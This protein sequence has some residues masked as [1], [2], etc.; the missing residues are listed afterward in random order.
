MAVSSDLPELSPDPSRAIV[1]KQ[2]PEQMMTVGEIFSR[3][4]EIYK[5]HP[6]IVVPSLFPILWAIVGMTILLAGFAGWTAFGDVSLLTATSI[7]GGMMLF[8]IVLVV[9]FVVAQGLTIVMIQDAWRGE[10]VTLSSGWQDARDK[11][12]TLVAASILSGILIALGYLLLIIPGLILTVALYF[13]A[14][15]V[16][17]DERGAIGSLS[18]SYRFVRANLEDAV[19]IIVISVALGL[20]LAV[21]P[22]VGPFLS[23]L[24]TPYIYALATLLYLDRKPREAAAERI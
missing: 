6:V 20:V 11:I 12:V 16:M 22:A 10:D 24:S 9:L 21:I 1:G 23:L 3:S 7:M 15:A 14:Q 13:V 2:E 17:I 19:V 5:N 8:S 4:W 18:A